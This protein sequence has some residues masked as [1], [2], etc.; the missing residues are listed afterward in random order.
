MNKNE[1][2]EQPVI[3]LGDVSHITRGQAIIELDVNGGQLR[4]GLGIVED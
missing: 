4:F 1:D 2:I 3:E